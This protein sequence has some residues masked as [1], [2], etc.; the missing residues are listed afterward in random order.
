MSRQ[1]VDPEKQQLG[2]AVFV[3]IFAGATLQLA[4]SFLGSLIGLHNDSRQIAKAAP[5][6]V[7]TKALNDGS[8]SE[9][10]WTLLDTKSRPDMRG[11]DMPGVLSQTILEE[12]DD[13][14]T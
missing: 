4:S 6:G 12:D 1:A 7:K 3:G 10:D 14:L 9:Q 8:S 5:R 11:R 13:S 2:C